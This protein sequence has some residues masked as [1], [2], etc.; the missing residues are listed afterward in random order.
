MEQ[1]IKSFTILKAKVVKKFSLFLQY[2]SPKLGLKVKVIFLETS[3]GFVN[4]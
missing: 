4:Q 3:H 1:Y 2:L